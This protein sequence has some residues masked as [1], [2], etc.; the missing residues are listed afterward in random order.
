MPELKVFETSCT[1][2]AGIK[3]WCDWLESNI[4]R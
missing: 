3:E 4:N 2:D 1:T